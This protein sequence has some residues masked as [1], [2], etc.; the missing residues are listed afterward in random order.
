MRL[1][2]SEGGSSLLDGEICLPTPERMKRDRFRKD[3]PALRVLS[4]V[5]WLY[6]SGD[7][8]D[9]EVAAA[10]RWRMEYDYAALGIVEDGGMTR[11]GEAGDVHTWMLG[12]GKCAQRLRHLAEILGP[13]LHA[14]IEMMLVREMSFPDM[15]RMIFPEGARAQARTKT[16]AQCALAL[17]RVSEYYNNKTCNINKNKV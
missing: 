2:A 1:C 16:A 11:G 12:R 5:A 6:E 4:T 14:R 3:G 13:S 10:Q 9:D 17:E 7:I 8:G 15:A